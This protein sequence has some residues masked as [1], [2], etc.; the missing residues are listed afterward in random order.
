MVGVREAVDFG[1][2]WYIGV[3]CVG[4]SWNLR[5]VLQVLLAMTGLMVSGSVW[6][7]Q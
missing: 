6:H 1:I 7:T 3:E 5:R 4:Q 2:R